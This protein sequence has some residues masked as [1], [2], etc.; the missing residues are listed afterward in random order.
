MK[1]VHTSLTRKLWPNIIFQSPHSTWILKQGGS[2]RNSPEI[3]V[4]LD[5]DFGGILLARDHMC[6][7]P[8][9]FLGS[10]VRKGHAIKVPRGTKTPI[11]FL[12]VLLQCYY[13]SQRWVWIRRSPEFLKHVWWNVGGGEIL[14]VEVVLGISKALIRS[15]LWNHRWRLLAFRKGQKAIH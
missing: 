1:T 11:P 10:R 7:L 6:V 9:E 13:A 2:A 12:S 5:L 4:R 8:E 14:G 3:W 15:T